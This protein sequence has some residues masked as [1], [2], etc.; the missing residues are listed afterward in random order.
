ML[1]QSLSYY[2]N[3]FAGRIANRVLQTSSAVRE[4]VVEVIDALWFAAIHWVGAVVLFGAAD[5]R[6]T[7]PLLVW[8]GLYGVTLWYFVPRIEKFSHDASQA[9]SAL[10][11]NIVDAY[12]NILT[13]KLFAHTDREDD[14][15]KAAMSHH[16][17][18]H[19]ISQRNLTTMEFVLFTLN[20]V[21][22]VT[23]SG[24]AIWLWSVQAITIGAVAL[25][26]T[27]VIRIVGMSNWIL[28]TVADVFENIGIVDEGMDTI[29]KP[30]ELVDRPGAKECSL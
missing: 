23:A 22:M 28:W 4:S 29:S 18:K 16:L 27:L 13:V 15:A 26:T 1:R 20:G 8:M 17:E 6:L 10:T 25:T 3:D 12:T 7:L 30:L 5:W 24:L 21:L 9:R 2:Q 19:L 14:N 11:G